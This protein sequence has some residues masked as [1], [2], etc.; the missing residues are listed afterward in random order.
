MLRGNPGHKK[1]NHEEPQPEAL[2]ETSALGKCPKWLTGDAREI[3]KRVAPAAIRSGLLR[4]V[5]LPAFEAFCKSYARWREFERLTGKNLE[6]A[7]SKGYRNAAVKERQLML[8][9][10]GRFGFDPSSRSNVKV[11]PTRPQ[12][13]VDNFRKAKTGA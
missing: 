1:I 5:D 12:T 7:I 9:F 4:V 10:G 8:Q 6:L 3:W 2:G 13:Q 11:T